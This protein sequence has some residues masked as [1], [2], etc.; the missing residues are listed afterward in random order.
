MVSPDVPG[1]TSQIA[2]RAMGTAWTLTSFMK[3]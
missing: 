2:I 1:M 3:S